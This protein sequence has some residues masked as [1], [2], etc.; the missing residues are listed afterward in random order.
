MEVA[1]LGMQRTAEIRV[2]LMK[3]FG[4]AGEDVEARQER[5]EAG[6]PALIRA[7]TIPEGVNIPDK[8]RELETERCAVYKLCPVEKEV[9]TSLAS[10]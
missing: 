1:N 7:S 6:M 4:V 10:G 9:N 8:L 3:Q 5:F 2:H